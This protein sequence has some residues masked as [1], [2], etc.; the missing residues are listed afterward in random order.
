M[1]DCSIVDSIAQ[2]KPADPKVF[3]MWNPDKVEA[4]EVESYLEGAKQAWPHHLYTYQ[5]E[6]ALCYL[7]MK[8]YDCKEALKAM[9]INI[10]EIICLIRQLF[11]RFHVS[12]SF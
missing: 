5:E 11:D 3:H 9:V 12:L 1:P 2:N 7:S 6:V 4:S 8:D 10:D